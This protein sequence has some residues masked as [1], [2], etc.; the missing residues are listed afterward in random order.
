MKEPSQE[1]TVVIRSDQFGVFVKE[2]YPTGSSQFIITSRI[3]A[4]KESVEN[5]IQM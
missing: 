4:D 1:Q 5:M 2:E 3:A